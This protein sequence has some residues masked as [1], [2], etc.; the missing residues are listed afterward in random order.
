MRNAFVAA[1]KRPGG[2]HLALNHRFG[3]NIFWQGRGGLKLD[4]LKRHIELLM[5]LEDI[6]AYIVVHIGGNDLGETRLG[7]LHYK[8]KRF[9]MWLSHK[10]SL[11]QLIYSQIL[12]RTYWRYSSDN[13]K[14]DKCRRRLNSS[15]GSLMVK[16]GGY[17]I[18][19]PDIRKTAQFISADGV[20]LTAL[21]NGIF[22]NTL[23]GALEK[24]ICCKGGVAFP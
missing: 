20:H 12:P 11:T 18:H 10:M 16:N 3:V 21:G 22:L 17:Y 24:F 5:T 14:I 7:L 15:I 19:Y 8:L 6:P 4:K 1:K 23:Q 2:I 9:M 13:N